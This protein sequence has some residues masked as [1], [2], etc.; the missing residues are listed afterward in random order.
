LLIFSVAALA[1]GWIGRLVGSSY[2]GDPDQNPG[3]LLWIVLPLLSAVLL[4]IIFRTG[5]KDAELKPAL[6]SNGSWYLIS[7]LPAQITYST[8][9]LKAKVQLNMFGRWT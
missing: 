9:V 2:T 3:L 5:W 4:R 6:K 1:S 8:E 7:I